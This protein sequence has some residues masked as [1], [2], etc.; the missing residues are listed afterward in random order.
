MLITDVF[1]LWKHDLMH[2]GLA[3]PGVAKINHRHTNQWGDHCLPT[4]VL[5]P[6]N[7]TARVM[8]EDLLDQNS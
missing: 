5:S 2:P 3:T 4:P 7:S 6:A 8:E 1:M